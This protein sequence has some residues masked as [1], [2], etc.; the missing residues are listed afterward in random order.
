MKK[1]ILI[2]FLVFIVFSCKTSKAS[3][4]AYG[5]VNHDNNTLNTNTQVLY[6]K[7]Q[8]RD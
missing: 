1:I 3:C 7:H 4:D 5:Y 6:P 2:G 8:L